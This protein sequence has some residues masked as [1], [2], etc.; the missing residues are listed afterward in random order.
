MHAS[1]ISSARNNPQSKNIR[2]VAKHFESLFTSMMVRAMRKTVGENTFLPQNTGEKIYTDLLDDEYAKLMA[3]NV[4]SGLTNRIVKELEQ[5]S[6]S[7]FDVASIRN[8]GIHHRLLQNLQLSPQHFKPN[9]G[10]STSLAERIEKWD[11]LIQAA[12]TRHNVDHQLIRAVIAQESAGNQYAVSHAGAKGLMQLM[13]GT[14]QQLGVSNS[15]SP[16]QNIDGGTRYLRMLLDQFDG[17]ETLALAGYNAGPN[18]VKRYNGIPPYEE[19]RDYVRSVL[20]FRQRFEENVPPFA[21][22]E[23]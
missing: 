7:S 4:S 3:N 1:S 2:E 21:G 14:A 12:S 15:F 17:D 16:S 6:N 22:M 23:K 10:I 20:Q 9:K 11:N 8:A 19:T 13:D 5:D 18:A